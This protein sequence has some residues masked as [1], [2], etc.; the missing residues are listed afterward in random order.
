MAAARFRDH[1][2]CMA[3]A[4]G[5]QHQC[6]GILVGHEIC[7][8]SQLPGGHLIVDNVL[9][10][11]WHANSLIESEKREDMERL[12]LVMSRAEWDAGVRYI[13]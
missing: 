2:R 10:V 8:R 11:C 12:R 5:L 4:R 1:G 9:T 6:H 7:K 3:L 13:P